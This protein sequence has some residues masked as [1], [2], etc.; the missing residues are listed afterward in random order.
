MPDHMV[1]TSDSFGNLNCANQSNP[2]ARSIKYAI[3]DT[4]GAQIT[5]LSFQFREA[6][7]NR[8]GDSCGATVTTSESCGT[9]PVNNF[10]DQLT[11][12]CFVGTPSTPCGWTADQQQ[13]Q[14][15]AP[16]GS[17]PS[18]GTP[19]A[20]SVHN[21]LVGVG[22]GLLPGFVPA[23]S[24]RSKEEHDEIQ[25]SIL[26]LLALEITTFGQ[27]RPCDS[28]E[29]TGRVTDAA[30]K[31]VENAEVTTLPELCAVFTGIGPGGI[32]DNNGDFHL[33]G[34]PEGP[35]TIFAKKEEAGYPD[36]R[37][38]VFA[39]DDS[40]FPRVV[41]QPGVV[42]SGIVVTLGKKAGIIFGNVVDA[43]TGLPI[44]AARVVVTR[45]DKA[46]LMYST[47]VG[48]K[49]TF[50]FCC[51]RVRCGCRSLRRDTR[52]GSA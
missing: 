17:R 15:C 43:E 41:V 25:F 2:V 21:D 50:A 6:F 13:W 36:A 31:P 34:V 22:G 14:W 26:L 29:I 10:I 47:S 30:G 51:R 28:G 7:A 12:G 49:G 52:P 16:N 11:V 39:S 18:I 48:L 9:L 45:V 23:M 38:A 8:S 20:L 4:S 19:G 3:I 37:F 1:V 42:T 24:R 46:Q 32:T 5:T 44:V 35:N 40:N 27:Q 33:R